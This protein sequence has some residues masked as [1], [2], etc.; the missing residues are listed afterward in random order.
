MDRKPQ[1]RRGDVVLAE[2]PF[3]NVVRSKL[4]PV[5][6]V[7]NDVANRPR[8]NLM[9]VALSSHVPPKPLP[10]HFVVS[11]DSRLAKAAGLVRDSV[12]DCGVIHTLPKK[13]IRRRIG[14]LP[15]EA[16]SQIDHCLKISLSLP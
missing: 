12:V 11:A 3:A 1:Y 5:L 2:L 13:R 9:V 16:I 15:S 10:T 14:T 6:V 7:Q 8:D 4:R